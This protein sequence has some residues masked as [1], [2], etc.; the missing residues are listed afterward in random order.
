[1]AVFGDGVCPVRVG[2]VG[3]DAVGGFFRFGG[4]DGVSRGVEGGIVVVCGDGV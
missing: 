2:E 3:D 4:V 1:M